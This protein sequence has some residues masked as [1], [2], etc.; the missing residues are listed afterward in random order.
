MLQAARSD[1]TTASRK[2]VLLDLPVEILEIIMA[3]I[4][5]DLRPKRDGPGFA[6]STAQLSHQLPSNQGTNRGPS[7]DMFQ[8]YSN[9]YVD[10]DRT[11]D[12]QN[13]RLTCKGLCAVSTQFLIPVLDVW[14]TRES[15]ERLEAVSQHPVIS[16][17]VYVVQ[18]HT[19]H[20]V[21]LQPFQR[22]RFKQDCMTRVDIFLRSLGKRHEDQTPVWT[23]RTGDRSSIDRALD[24]AVYDWADRHSAARN[25]L[26]EGSFV[27]AVSSA[28]ARMP[29]ANSLCISDLKDHSEGETC[30]GWKKVLPLQAYDLTRLASGRFDFH[31]KRKLRK[32]AQSLV[33]DTVKRLNGDFDKRALQLGLDHFK[34]IRKLPWA[35]A[36][37]GKHLASL[38]IMIATPHKPNAFL[39]SNRDFIDEEG[40]KRLKH[41]CRNLKY[42]EF[43]T[44]TDRILPST[45]RLHYSHELQHIDSG[46]FT[47]FFT[48]C[49]GSP[50]LEGLRIGV[51]DFW[52][53]PVVGIG[54]TAAKLFEKI[55]WSAITSNRLKY[56]YLFQ[57]C[58]Q[59]SEL[60][61]FLAQSTRTDKIRLRLRDVSNSG[62]KSWTETLDFLRKSGK[63]AQTSCLV[64]LHDKN[65]QR[66]LELD[67]FDNRKAWKSLGDY[68]TGCID[69]NPLSPPPPS[70][71]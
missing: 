47:H 39:G 66:N 67:K 40:R 1:G 12:I 26:S 9:F 22:Y 69:R 20:S 13:V 34:L 62:N 5:I 35:I 24:W 52:F 46:K 43:Q 29:R 17:A 56:L 65:L 37:R 53:P 63:I 16:K 58:V 31:D 27:E 28:M 64:Y 71:E 49:M 30:P 38:H 4:Q 44:Y 41:A 18:L 50:S 59:P 70:A 36:V 23:P 55:P 54:L 11:A 45:V 21:K 6:Y 68:I 8:R 57:M 25:M 48:A 3:N 33:L 14:M 61:T 2:P 15:L 51:S 7:P 32:L 42:F 10:P 60:E 19:T